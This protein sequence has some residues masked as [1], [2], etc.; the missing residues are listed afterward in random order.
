[1]SKEN[2]VFIV[3]LDEK[4]APVEGWFYDLELHDGFVS[5]T[6]MTKDESANRLFIPSQRIIKIKKRQGDQTWIRKSST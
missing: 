2:E 6:T 4:N 3:Y 1:M 5:F